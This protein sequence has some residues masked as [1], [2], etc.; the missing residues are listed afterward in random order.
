VQIVRVHD[1]ADTRQAVAVWE[2][3]QAGSESRLV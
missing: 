3:A 2:A 1:V